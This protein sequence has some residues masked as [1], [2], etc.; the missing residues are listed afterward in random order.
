MS[1]VPIY[2]N[3]SLE[4]L[5]GEVWKEI[6]FTEGYYVVSN[7]GRVKALE[8]VVY[9]DTAPFG[10]RIKER[11]LSQNIGKQPNS[12]TNDETFGLSV[13]YQF[14]GTRNFAMVRRLVY[15]AF[16]ASKTNESMDDKFVYPLDGNGL[17]SRVENL[18][19]ATKSNLRLRDLNKERYL[20][21][22]HLLPKEDYV[23]FAIKAGRSRRKK[24]CK[25]KPDGTLVATYPSIS[26]AAEKNAT[27]VGNIGQCISKKIKSLRGFIFR[28]A[29]DKYTGELNGLTGKT[30]KITQYHP[31]GRMIK[32]YNSIIDAARLLNIKPGSISRTAVGKSKHAG[33]FVW[34][35]EDD[36]YRGEYK[37][38]LKKRKF[39]QLTLTG[40]RIKTF[41]S[42]SR[43]ANQ[44]GSPYES[45]RLTL[46][47]KNKTC[48]G[49]LWQWL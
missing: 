47:G 32:S 12:F 35:Y 39:V 28:Y 44:T 37:E 22:Y 3:K 14:E 9:S 48:N 38:I 5:K 23:R 4:D 7:L 1:E 27:S 42:I 46:H 18:G 31:D 8:R 30:T 41:D 24:I 34:R 33:G 40:K 6:P 21:P 26:K 20:P 49:Y 45:I 11:I 16:I 43:A 10:R 36:V 2:K 29:E 19:L 13:V 17:N 25:Y 15:E